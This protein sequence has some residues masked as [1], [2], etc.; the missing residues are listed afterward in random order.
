MAAILISVGDI[1]KLEICL[2]INEESIYGVGRSETQQNQNLGIYLIPPNLPFT[3]P[4]SG[5]GNDAAETFAKRHNAPM[6]KCRNL[7]C[8]EY[9][10]VTAIPD[11]NRRKDQGG[12]M[13]ISTSK[14]SPV[15]PKDA[16]SR[17]SSKV[18]PI[19]RIPKRIKLGVTTVA[20][21]R[22][23]QTWISVIICRLTSRFC[24]V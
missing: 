20:K 4:S 24:T 13:R 7:K 15:N 2:A 18:L 6:S 1:T 8:V 19:Q 11:L 10:I 23:N 17:H 21:S 22:M 12:L 9:A 16:G 14:K 3:T 5:R